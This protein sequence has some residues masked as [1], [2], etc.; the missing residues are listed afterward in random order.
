MLKCIAYNLSYL[1]NMFNLKRKHVKYGKCLRIRGIISIHGNGYI[2][3]GENVNIIS[4]PLVNP[5]GGNQRAYLQADK[6]GK[7][8]IGDNVGMTSPA[9]TAYKKV[10]IEDNVLIGRSV[11]IYDTDFH[12][13]DF[14][15]RLM[16][17]NKGAICSEIVIG[18][19]VFIGAHAI[20]LKGVHIG[21]HSI[22]GAGSVVSKDVPENEIWAGNPAKIIRRV[23]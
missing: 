9:I 19:G 21:K 2:E 18:E 6:N 11:C 10:T 8:I 12:S 4:T 14:S 17:G 16:G 20:I 13:L 1:I 7:I 22:I 23:E 15:T 3:M 5:I